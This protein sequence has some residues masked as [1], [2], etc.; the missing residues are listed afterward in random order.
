MAEGTPTAKT[1]R[2]LSRWAS[3]TLGLSV[4]M[5]VL[6]MRLN[7]NRKNPHATQLERQVAIPAPST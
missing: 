3:P 2:M 4:M 1:A 6:P 7:T 5:D